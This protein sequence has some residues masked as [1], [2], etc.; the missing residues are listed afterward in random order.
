MQVSPEWLTTLDQFRLGEWVVP[1]MGRSK[2]RLGLVTNIGNRYVHAHFI[3]NGVPVSE[4]FCPFHLHRIP[5]HETA[6][7]L[8]LDDFL[9]L[10]GQRASLIGKKPSGYRTPPASDPT[11]EKDGKIQCVICG[12]WHQGLSGHLRA[13]HGISTY[14][15]RERYN[16]PTII[17]RLSKQAAEDAARQGPK[18]LKKTRRYC[19][20]HIRLPAAL[21]EA[22][23]H[24]GVTNLHAWL[25]GLME[26]AI[27][28]TTVEGIYE[29]LRGLDNE[30]VVA[31]LEE[32]A[33]KNRIP[34]QSLNETAKWVL[35]VDRAGRKLSLTEL[36]IT[37]ILAIYRLDM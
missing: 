26:A 23:F 8:N 30:E 34:F 1:N 15:Y 21:S 20:A 17:S 24:L 32:V 35:N 16:A 9:E 27:S 10:N 12:E 29:N 13:S 25:Y 31:T 36:Q 33:V 3:V 4:G 18:P 28:K 37:A 11:K 22:I 14:E 19:Q 5:S 2:E 6:I 7:G